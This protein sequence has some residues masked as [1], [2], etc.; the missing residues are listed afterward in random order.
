MP[1]GH[2]LVLFRVPLQ[3]CRLLMFRNFS[4]L[5]HTSVYSSL[6]FLLLCFFLC[7]PNSFVFYPSFFLTLNIFLSFLSPPHWNIMTQYVFQSLL[8]FVYHSKISRSLWMLIFVRVISKSQFMMGFF[9]SYSVEDS[10]KPRT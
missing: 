10:F 2:V 5:I 7:F 1:Y 6:F 8:S 9:K 3:L 4:L